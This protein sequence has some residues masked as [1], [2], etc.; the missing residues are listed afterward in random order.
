MLKHTVTYEDYNGESVTE[1][2]Y[3]NI[4]EPELVE[5]EVAGGRGF[6]KL[7][8]DIVKSSDNA[9]LLVE[10]KKLV[11]LAYGEKSEDG[12]RFVKSEKLK[13][14]FSQTAAYPHIF[15]EL[16]SNENKAVAFFKGV[17]PK[18][19]ADGFDDAVKEAEKQIAAPKPP[20]TNA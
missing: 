15:M 11:L 7:I 6:T 1:T 16:L 9:A 14:E 18:R 12:K 8:E 20:T 5:L 13:E 3:F 17:L 4:T 10:F 2:F 19:F